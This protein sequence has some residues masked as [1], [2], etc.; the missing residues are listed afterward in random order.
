MPEG[1]LGR[2]IQ[3]P[4]SPILRGNGNPWLGVRGGVNMQNRSRL[5]KILG[6]IHTFND[7]EVIDG[8]MTALLEQTYPIQEILLVDNASTDGTLMRCFP[9]K[10]TI[11]RHEENMGTSGAVITGFKYALAKS[12]DWI[13]VLDADSTPRKDALEQLINLYQ[14]FPPDLQAETRMLSSLPFDAKTNSPQHGIVFTPKGVQEVVPDPSATYYEC[15]SN[16]WTGSLFKM[17]AVR[18]IG[19]PDPDFVLDWGDIEYGYKGMQC[20]YRGFIHQSSVLVHNLHPKDTLR[21]VRF[22]KRSVKIFSSP[23]VRF[24]YMWRN[25]TYFWLYE[26][27]NRNFFRLF[28]PHSFMFTRW[29]IKAVIFIEKPAPVVKACVHGFWDG[30]FKRLDRRY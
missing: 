9:D 16:M 22:G 21:Y 3:E 25:T 28:L 27:H 12:F 14:S 2:I 24:Y 6:Y 1:N 29:L 18:E 23:P 17:E 4:P 13:W 30:I 7:E 11:I 26:F 19:L 20:G 5:M 15:H 8:T 10:V